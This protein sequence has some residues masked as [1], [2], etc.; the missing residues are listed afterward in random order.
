MATDFAT[1]WEKVKENLANRGYKY[2]DET[3][4]AIAENA[5]AEGLDLKEI[6]ERCLRYIQGD[7]FSM[8]C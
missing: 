1:I 4:R 7:E 8:G 3:D 6:T 2:L 5:F